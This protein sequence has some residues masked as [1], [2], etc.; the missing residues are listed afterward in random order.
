MSCHD[1]VMISR[2]RNLYP[3]DLVHS[4]RRTIYLWSATSNAY[5][6]GYI[7][8]GEIA[9]IVANAQFD[10]RCGYVLVLG[11]QGSLGIVGEGELKG[12]KP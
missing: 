9:M 11:P 8:V 5:V 6:T 4:P 12:V 10:E 7:N 1:E 3:G 2:R